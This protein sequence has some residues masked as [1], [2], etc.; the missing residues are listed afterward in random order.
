VYALATLGIAIL[1]HILITDHM[2]LNNRLLDNE[3][4]IEYLRKIVFE[5]DVDISGIS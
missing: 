4:R 2:S 5:E 3:T 1:C